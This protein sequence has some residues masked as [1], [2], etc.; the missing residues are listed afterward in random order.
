MTWA[1]VEDEVA[2][3]LLLARIARDQDIVNFDALHL[4]RVAIDKIRELRL[5]A[6]IGD[7]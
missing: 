2:Q 6:V 5:T 4:A 7:C 3:A 1:E